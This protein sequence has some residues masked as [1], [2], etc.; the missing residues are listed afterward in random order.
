M[1]STRPPTTAI[2]TASERALGLA[3]SVAGE[4]VTFVSHDL[5]GEIEPRMVFF[6]AFGFERGDREEGDL[7]TIPADWFAARK[8]WEGCV[9]DC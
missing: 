8:V 3:M 2:D 9:D 7:S 6:L 4:S 1:L 5:A